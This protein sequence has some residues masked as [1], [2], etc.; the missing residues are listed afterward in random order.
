ML[1]NSSE[2]LWSLMKFHKVRR[3][4]MKSYKVRWSPLKSY[5]VRWS[6]LN[7]VKSCEVTKVPKSLLKSNEILEVSGSLMKFLEV[8]WSSLNSFEV[9]RSPSSLLKSILVF[10][11]HLKALEVFQTLRS[12][13]SHWKSYEVL[14]KKWSHIGGSLLNSFEVFEVLKS[15]VSPLAQSKNDLASEPSLARSTLKSPNTTHLREI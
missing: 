4:P 7:L 13:S 9:S 12:L 3:S 10:R 1:R 6:P 8:S 2:V 11:N 5:E 14:R 15:A